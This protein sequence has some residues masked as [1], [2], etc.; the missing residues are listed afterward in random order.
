MPAQQQK[1]LQ[2][3]YVI[4]IKIIKNRWGAA[5]PFPTLS[6]SFFFL[7]LLHHE[8]TTYYLSTYLC[9][10]YMCDVRY[11]DKHRAF[12]FH[13]FA[14]L[15]FFVLRL[16]VALYLL[17][18]RFFVSFSFL[19]NRPTPPPFH[20]TESVAT[21]F[22]NFFIFFVFKIFLLKK[23]RYDLFTFMECLCRYWMFTF[24]CGF[25]CSWIG[26]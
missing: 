1:N 13:S 19:L 9:S 18:E 25:V 26:V 5:A 2:K 4:I 23:M 22:L 8:S 10:I 6:F 14:L 20:D 16:C 24:R 7:F 3:K 21:P 11:T 12:L 17:S 15:G